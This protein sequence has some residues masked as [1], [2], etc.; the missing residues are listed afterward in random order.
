MARGNPRNE[1][2]DMIDELLPSERNR[3]SRPAHD[4]RRFRDRLLHV[5]RVGCPWRDMHEQGQAEL[6][7]CSLPMLG[8]ARRRKA[9][10]STLVEFAQ[11]NDW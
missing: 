5:L 7:L 8:R 11:T 3:K 2:R 4:N 10:L 9:I 6:D 1:K